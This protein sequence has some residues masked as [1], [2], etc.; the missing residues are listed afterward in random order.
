MAGMTSE[1]RKIKVL[2]IITRF[3][4]GGS[5]EN[6]YLTLIGLSRAGYDLIL[7]TGPSDES[8]SGERER[9][10]VRA[11]LERA[12]RAGIRIVRIRGLVRNMKP[13][14][15]LSAFLELL[16]VVRVEKPRIVH[17]HTSKAGILGR[18]A[19]W[20]CRVP[21]IVHTPH[22]HVF[23][24][25]FGL[26]ET[27]LYVT[28][29][30]ITARITDRIVA[31]TGQERD[32]HLRF[33]VAPPEK[34]VTI[35]SGVDLSRFDAALYDRSKIRIELDIPPGDLV[36]GTAGRLTPVKGHV[37]LIAAAA[38]ILAVHPDTTFVLLGDG[39]L[40][41]RL[42]EQ[43]EALGLAGKVRFP[44]WRPDVAAVMSAFDVFVLP[45]LNEGMGRVLVE[46]MA[47]SKPV[48]ASRTGGIKDLV[49]DG[50]NGLLVPPG[51]AGDLAD[52]ILRLLGDAALR[53]AMGGEGRRRAE[54]YSAERMV[55]KIEELYAMSTGAGRG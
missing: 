15:D 36:V 24:G 27:K 30:K 11:N 53:A 2:H 6:T 37:H 4:K 46:A 35:H 23:W 38:K 43:A 50:S 41:G 47:L 8:Q 34:F 1:R 51:D 29:E 19:A 54:I 7:V 3:D 55:E 22:G 45:S 5:A 13:G 21:V 10:A 25:Y 32:D 33:R 39:E 17:T 28:L 12:E 9:E 44:G 48:V 20:L 40:K 16:R 31:L 52:A 49:A 14:G 18:W 26:L 42:I